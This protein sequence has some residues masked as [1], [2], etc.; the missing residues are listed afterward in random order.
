MK[1]LFLDHAPALTGA[2]IITLNLAA[3]LDRAEF[4]PIFLTRDDAALLA[5]LRARD[6]PAHSLYLDSA[7]LLS[8][9]GV[10]GVARAVR[11]IVRLVRREQVDVMISASAR[12]HTLSALAAP[13]ARVP[14]VWMLHDHALSRG[15]RVLGRFAARRIAVSSFVAEFFPGAT[16]IY[17]GV[18][19]AH[20]AAANDL[21]DKFKIPRDAFL[22]V[23][24]GQLTR[25]KGQ[26]VLLR[27]AAR[28]K[29]EMPNLHL[30]FVGGA[31]DLG[32]AR[33]MRELRDQENLRVTLA[34]QR[35]DMPRWLA[36]AD[37]FCYSAIEPEGMPL[38][39]VEA[40]ASGMPIIASDI[41]T[42]RELIAPDGGRLIAPHDEN[43]LA[44]AL[45]MLARDPELRVRLGNAA[46]ARAT[47]DF[48]P[49]TQA[50]QYEKILSALRRA[51]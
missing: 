47:R 49:R 45:K 1:I 26:T 32:Y 28:L 31:S 25:A 22:V 12:M 11:T 29:N 6:I 13:L 50:A 19:A 51:P 21:R 3:A 38:A 43:A 44:D 41:G 37:L 14:L 5:Q 24:V 2:E 30:A 34:G 18:R 46:R 20:I 8:S 16:V 17:P 39:L 35:D 10:R 9:R 15:A 7:R 40:M 48:D 33:E 23:S 42:A 27:A 4:Q 36:A